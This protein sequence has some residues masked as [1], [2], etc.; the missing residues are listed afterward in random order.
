[1]WQKGRRTR[2][3]GSGCK[4][5]PSIFNTVEPLQMM[6]ER[7]RGREKT[8]REREGGVLQQSKGLLWWQ[9]SE[10]RDGQTSG[11]KDKSERMWKKGQEKEKEESGGGGWTQDSINCDGGQKKSWCDLLLA[12]S[13]VPSHLGRIWWATYRHS[14][15]ETNSDTGE[16]PSLH[17]TITALLLHSR[18]KKMS[19][20]VELCSFFA[21]VTGIALAVR[22]S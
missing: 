8:R 4:T 21:F 3:V 7:E 10:E 5:P 18:E 17:C 1:M 13:P 22:F 15:W 2:R 19:G 16:V 11:K 14:T 9:R 6:G 12:S 20:N